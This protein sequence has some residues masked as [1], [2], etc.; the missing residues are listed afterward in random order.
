MG[1]LDNHDK[2]L[3]DSYENFPKGRYVSILLVRKTKSETIFRTESEG[4]LNK[5]F[6]RVGEDVEQRVVMTKRKQIAVE[7]RTGRELLRRY[8]KLF[9]EGEDVC[10]LNRNNPC[11]ECIDC[12]LYGFAVGGGGA[13]KSR[14]ISNDAYSLLPAK[15]VTDKRT[16]NALYDNGTMRDPL[17]KEKASTSLGEVEYIKPETHFIDIETLKDVTKEELIYVLGNILRSKR[18]GAISSRIGKMDNYVLG[19]YFSDCE[20]LSNLELTQKVIG[21]FNDKEFPL[22]TAEVSEVVKTKMEESIGEVFGQVVALEGEEL[23]ELLTEI[24]EIYGDDAKLEELLD[25]AQE[26]YQN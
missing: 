17:N 3:A 7:R 4:G 11:G 12:M 14:V 26:K 6:V 16:F 22:A 20:L 24:K 15:K 18:Y 2:F 23:A 1:V 19:I 13:Q 25:T 8:D 10:A 9:G 5:E 21:E